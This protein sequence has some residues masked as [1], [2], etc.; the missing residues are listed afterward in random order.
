MA[1]LFILLNIFVGIGSIA[2]FT[3]Y[4]RLNYWKY[5]GLEY[6]KLSIFRRTTSSES[7]RK[8]YGHFKN[9]CKLLGIFI[10]LKPAILILNLEL[11]KTI[12]N[13]EINKFS[14]TNARKFNNVQ[15]KHIRNKL[16]P[17]FNSFKIK[18]MFPIVARGFC[19]ILNSSVKDRKV[20][21]LD[22]TKI[23]DR[24][25]SD[26]IGSIVF[27]RKFSKTLFTHEENIGIFRR[28]QQFLKIKP[29]E[30]DLFLRNVRKCI[31]TPNIHTNFIASMMNIHN[32]SK[33]DFYDIVNQSYEFLK[34]GFQT[35]SSTIN[36]CIYELAKNQN[37]QDSVR[38][39]ILLTLESDNWEFTYETLSKMRILK[40]VFNGK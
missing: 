26:V 8:V 20:C 39:E 37:L 18:E 1:L 21:D 13:D 25:T 19:E 5:R 6:E 36:C 27:G 28:I 12:L 32:R 16:A 24:N 23:I 30:K 31:E 10:Y 9:K 40:K 22:I 7:I 4:R 11:A 2:F 29:S 15:T 35:S 3:F 34:T 38:N 17:N 14:D 33:I